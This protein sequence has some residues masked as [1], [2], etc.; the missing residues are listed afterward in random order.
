MMMMM[1]SL[2][3]STMNIMTRFTD[4]KDGD[5]LVAEASGAR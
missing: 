2:A 1:E 5:L 3:T 4:G